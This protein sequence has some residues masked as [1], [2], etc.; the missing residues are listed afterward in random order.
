MSDPLGYEIPLDGLPDSLAAYVPP[1]PDGTAPMDRKGRLNVT[2]VL[3]ANPHPS[4]VDA[5]LPGAL[6]RWV[7]GSQSRRWA[8]IVAAHGERARQ[9][10]FELASAGIV[11]L[12]C[13]VTADATLGQ[14]ISMRLT[15]SW[16]AERKEL[17]AQ[18]SAS[19]DG[20]ES[21]ARAAAAKIEA[22]DPVFAD[23]LGAAHGGSR[24]IEILTHAAEDIVAGIAH[25]GPRAFSQAH[26]ADTKKHEDAPKILRDAGVSA[27]TIIALGL[28]RSP[29]VGL[30]GPI[31]L[32]I[33]GRVW[34]LTHN[35]GPTLVRLTGSRRMTAR[36]AAK[37][38]T[39]TML[40]IENLQA[41]E[42][43]NDRY[44][45]LP[46]LYCTGQPS[47]DTLHLLTE[48]T[49]GVDHVFIATDADL[50]GV[51]IAQRLLTA[52]REVPT[53]VLDVGSAPHVEGRSFGR[54]TLEALE[55]LATGEGK[56]STFARSCLSR[57][58]QVEQEAAIRTVVVQALDHQST[59]RTGTDLGGQPT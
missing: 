23:V 47:D 31:E 19:A 46:I 32:D 58:Y 8:G 59:A 16:D 15:P 1:R 39:S 41:A 54:P 50:G 48:L 37:R 17:A 5:P 13:S 36:L 21:R 6:R 29:Y 53:T 45:K 18:S 35:A 33:A 27:E 10:S 28:D 57:G 30:A 20:W 2:K 42:A 56:I 7:L 25:E 40:V 11:Q 12:T 24:R 4:D 55:R 51:R 43:M 44:P 9:V 34:D 14:V 49:A 26:F 52:L 3:V 38:H 22:I